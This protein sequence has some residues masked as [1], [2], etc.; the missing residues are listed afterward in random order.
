[1]GPEMQ[2]TEPVTNRLQGV[3]VT[4]FRHKYNKNRVLVVDMIRNM[5]FT[6]MH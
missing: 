4:K 1:M 6:L 3:F 5:Y 2:V